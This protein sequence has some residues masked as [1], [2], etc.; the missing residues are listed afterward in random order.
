MVI[1]LPVIIGESQ[2]LIRQRLDENVVDNFEAQYRSYRKQ[3]FSINKINCLKYFT[4]YT[5]KKQRINFAKQLRKSSVGFDFR[6]SV[7]ISY[8]PLYFL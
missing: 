3:T 8:A 2:T 6:I 1:V 7:G 5:K 4:D